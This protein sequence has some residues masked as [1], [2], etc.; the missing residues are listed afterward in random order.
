MIETEQFR[1]WLKTNTAYSDAVIS[2]TISRVK[3]ADGILEWNDNEVY[4]FYLERNE[5]Y[6]SLSVS[7]RSQI[8]KAV[9]LYRTYHISQANNNDALEK[10]ILE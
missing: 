5:I 10:I 1:S 7:V 9:R 8:K 3:R 4:Q 6:Q 2:D